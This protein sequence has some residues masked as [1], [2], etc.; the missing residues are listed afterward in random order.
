MS[1]ELVTRQKVCELTELSRSTLYEKLSAGDFPR[2]ISRPRARLKWR[3]ADIDK[4]LADQEAQRPEVRER[5]QRELERLARS[6]RKGEREKRRRAAAFNQA[7]TRERTAN[8]YAASPLDDADRRRLMDRLGLS[9][10]GEQFYG[11]K[12][13]RRGRVYAPSL[14]W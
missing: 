1:D 2:P 10:D 13:F 9:E 6:P 7:G 8:P 14:G 3:K 5:S 4:W 11:S 12:P